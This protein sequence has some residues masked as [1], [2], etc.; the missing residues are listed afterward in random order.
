[1]NLTW[2]NPNSEGQINLV[3]NSQALLGQDCDSEFFIQLSPD[4]VY[5]SVCLYCRR[6]LVTWSSIGLDSEQT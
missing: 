1:M 5:Y 3:C 2:R 6:M 4:P